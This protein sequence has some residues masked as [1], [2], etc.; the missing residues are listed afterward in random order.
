MYRQFILVLLVA[1]VLQGCVGVR[2]SKKTDRKADKIIDN[3]TTEVQS[4]N[5]ELFAA[6][7]EKENEIQR[8]RDAQ[9]RIIA[10][11]KQEIKTKD[12]QVQISEKGLVIT[13]LTQIF[14]NSG[15]SEIKASGLKSLDKITKTL[16]NIKRE[17]R[18][19][20]HTDNEP[21]RRTKHLYKSNWELSA[22]R[23]MSVLHYLQKRG[24]K[25]KLLSAA[26]Y[27][28]HRPL[29]KNSNDKNKA[30]NRRVEI[31]VLPKKIKLVDSKIPK[32]QCSLKNK[33]I[34]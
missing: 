23:A 6:K 30:K 29:V 12:A 22:A 2:T 26:G 27:G 32:K 24:V 1:F 21:I 14:F 18:V 31:V 17:I 13:F 3:L 15:K 33:K 20:G 16:K 11:L 5:E 19:E 10:E 4:L 25:P 28:E 34:K 9:M 8:L 7:E